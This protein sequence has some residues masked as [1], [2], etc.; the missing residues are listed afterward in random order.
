MIEIEIR[1]PLTPEGTEK[2]REFF[3]ANGELL[4]TQDREMILLF[5]YPGYAD[6]PIK[7]EVDVRLRSTDGKCEV[8]IKRKAHEHNA[9]R[10]EH[11]IP[12]SG[13]LEDAKVLAKGF[14]C[15][16]G[17]WMHRKKEVYSYNGVEWSVV[18]AVAAPGKDGKDIWYYEAEQEV[19]EGADVEEVRQALA[20]E[21]AA[22]NLSIFT[23]DEYHEFVNML[24]REVNQQ[25]EW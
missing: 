16:R 17:L 6:D 24:G 13:T 25:I 23:P 21:A 19:A 18:E 11:S 8:M 1:G 20:N 12:I 4:E 14:G 22:L 15:A 3:R 5:D 9:G 7:R 2:L 10:S